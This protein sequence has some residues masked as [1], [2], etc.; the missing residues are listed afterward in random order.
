ME[1]DLIDSAAPFGCVRQASVL[2]RER[3]RR[4]RRRGPRGKIALVRRSV[5]KHHRALPGMSPGESGDSMP[6][7][8]RI[9]QSLACSE[10]SRTNIKIW[11]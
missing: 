3:M 8:E 10:F 9:H 4:L 11:Q 7:L 2:L 5:P 1:T 6:D